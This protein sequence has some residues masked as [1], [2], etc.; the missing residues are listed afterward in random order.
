MKKFKML[1]ILLIAI[2][3]L[4]INN[5]KASDVIVG[6]YVTMTQEEFDNLKSQGFSEFQ[7]L[8]IS[9]SEF[10]RLK[11]LKGEVVS[12]VTKYYKTT[13]PSSNFY[14]SNASRNTQMPI[15]EEITKEEY[16]AIGENKSRV[17]S[18]LETAAK[19]ITTTIAS[20]SGKYRYNISTNWKQMPSARSYDV[21]GIGYNSNVKLSGTPTFAQVFCTSTLVSS[22]SSSTA[23]SIK[24]ASTGVAASFVLKSGT[25][26]TITVGLYFDVVKNTTSTIKSQKA[27]GHYR[28]ADGNI[29]YDPI[30]SVS[31]GDY[32]V[33]INNEF[34]PKYEDMPTVDATWNG[35]W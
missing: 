34:K 29:T 17:S 16:D 19:N 27:I 28:H 33:I 6:N 3:A 23:H 2:G 7:I 9:E 12:R 20:V 18:P 31:V 11:D 5:V 14:T 10:E 21:T 22:C 26:K 32:G 4:S 15:T 24:K 13:Y 35:S 1:T 30:N 25:Y 8:N